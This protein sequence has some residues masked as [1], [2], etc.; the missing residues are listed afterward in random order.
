M[1]SVT[2]K[3]DGG[4][5]TDIHVCEILYMTRNR[6][7]DRVEIITREQLY[8]LPGPLKYWLNVINNR[9]YNFLH[10][11]RSTA[12]NPANVVSVNEIYKEAFFDKEVTKKSIK[13]EI[14]HHRY[15]EFVEEL[16]SSN[17][18]VVLT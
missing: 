4:G 7:L 5:T 11:D 14:A 1:L 15:R 13:C 9:G 3:P 10:V 8:Y 16:T 12:I 2:R 18:R 17:H 6:I